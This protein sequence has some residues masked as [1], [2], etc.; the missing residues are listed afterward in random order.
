MPAIP[1]EHRCV[2][3]VRDVAD[4]H[5]LAVKKPLAANKRFAIVQSS[6]SFHDYARPIVEKYSKLGWP[7]T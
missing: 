6:P 5:L 1:G 4:A 7:C 3:D 2:V